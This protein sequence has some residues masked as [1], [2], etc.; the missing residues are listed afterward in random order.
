MTVILAARPLRP[1][2]PR[3]ERLFDACLASNVASIRRIG[4]PDLRTSCVEYGLSGEGSVSRNEK[5]PRTMS[6]G[7]F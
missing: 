7:F 6:E 4:K 3:W 5:S 2:A 1:S